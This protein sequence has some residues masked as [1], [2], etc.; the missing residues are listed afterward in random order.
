MPSDRELIETGHWANC[1]ICFDAFRRQRLT[2]RFCLDC[3]NGF[4]EGEHGNFAY[5]HGKCII[6]G[7]KRSY[8][9][10]RPIYKCEPV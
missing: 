1:R 5:G 3:G 9:Q 2:L 6:C 7:E 8:R 10:P 4:C